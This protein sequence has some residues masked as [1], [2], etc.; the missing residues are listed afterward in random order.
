[1]VLHTNQRKMKNLEYEFTYLEVHLI[2]Q[3]CLNRNHLK[4][5]RH[6]LDFRQQ[7]TYSPH[8]RIENLKRDGAHDYGGHVDSF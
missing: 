2:L 6:Y 5:H 8:L 4:D 1:M 3:M 7:M